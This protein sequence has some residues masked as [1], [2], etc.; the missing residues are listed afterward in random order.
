MI[1]I[2]YYLSWISFVFFIVFFLLLIFLRKPIYGLGFFI[3][4]PTLFFYAKYN[5]LL[6]SSKYMDLEVICSIYTYEGIDLTSSSRGER[7]KIYYFLFDNYGEF[8]FRNN[9]EKYRLDFSKLNVNDRI[10]FI[11]QRNNE[12]KTNLRRA[13]IIKVEK[14]DL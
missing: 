8:A 12:F 13:K 7:S 5:Q 9:V 2:Y 6:P 4:I 3:I 10:C 11:L 1:N 14:G